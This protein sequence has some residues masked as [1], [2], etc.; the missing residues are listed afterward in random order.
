[1][2]TN[3]QPYNTSEYWMEFIQ[4]EL[5]LH[6]KKYMDEKKMNQSQ[7]ATEL[8]VNKSF[9]AQVLKG[10]FNYTLSKLIDFSL[11]VGLVPN[12]Q[13]KSINDY[14]L[15]KENK[16]LKREINLTG[17][18]YLVMKTGKTKLSLQGNLSGITVALDAHQVNTIT[19]SETKI[20]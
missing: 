11:A 2:R 1:M 16:R 20:A 19:P 7:L 18:Q 13:F 10:K 12:I 14:L 6:V 5:S 15:H 3:D 8:G 17:N 4:N 9:I